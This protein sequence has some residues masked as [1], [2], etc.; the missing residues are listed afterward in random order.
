MPKRDL[1]FKLIH[2]LD[3][4]EKRHFSLFVKSF[5]KSN[6]QLALF[7]KVVLL[8]TKHG[9]KIIDDE[10]L[11]LKNERHLITRKQYLYKR[12]LLALRL[13]YNNNSIA[14]EIQNGLCEVEILYNKRLGHNC[15]EVLKKLRKQ[16]LD[17]EKFGLLIQ[18]LDWERKLVYIMDV[19]ERTE[20]EITAEEIEALKKHYNF[21]QYSRLFSKAMEFK[22][23]YGYV[24]GSSKLAL[25]A[26]LLNVKS[27]SHEKYC[28][29][30]GAY[31]HFYHTKAICSLMLQHHI[32]QYAYSK[33]MIALDPK[34]T[35]GELYFNGLL[36][37]LSSAVCMGYF[38][39]VLLL[40]R[41]TEKL[42]SKTIIPNTQLNLRFF[43]YKTNYSLIAFTYM[44]NREEMQ[45]SL[46]RMKLEMEMYKEK[47]NLEIKLVFYTTMI[48][49]YFILGEFQQAKSKLSEILDSSNKIIRKDI[50]E[51]GLICS[52]FLWLELKESDLLEYAIRSGQRYFKNAAQAHE[53]NLIVETELF[54][55]CKK[56]KE[57]DNVDQVQNFYLATRKS[58]LNFIQ[59]NKGLNQFSEYYH[60]YLL[61]CESRINKT[62][63]LYEAAKWYKKHLS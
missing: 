32:D 53:S 60:L 36:T 22:K 31:F 13:Y 50:Y 3:K 20:G 42:L 5:K 61:I 11:N 4:S 19:P 62:D 9:K 23:K 8:K 49:T 41:S 55:N 10:E 40:I 51:S 14:T 12:L 48:A 39:E 56:I 59:Q 46:K 52:I 33:K 21:I 18:V 29:S 57:L 26:E 24:H 47:M 35:G 45:N 37:H 16:A 15:L 27:L 2:S 63:I 54:R 34:K 38:E 25:E 30:K 58:I 28:L 6:A 43:Y 7:E 1:L 44:G 17:Y